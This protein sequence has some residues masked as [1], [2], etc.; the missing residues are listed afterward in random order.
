MPWAAAAAVASAVVGGVAANKAASKAA[1]ANQKAIDANAYQ[2]QIALDQFDDY[3]TTFRPLEHSLASDAQQ[4][5]SAQGYERA[6]GEAQAAVSSQLGLARARLMRTPGL[7]PSSAAAQAAHTNL[8][9]HGAAMAATEQNL[10]R[11]R[12]RDKAFARKLDA[13]GLGRGLVANA[14]TGFAN[15]AS[16][17][18]SLARANF[19]EGNQTAAGIGSLVNGVVGGLSKVNW[20]KVG[21]IF[22]TGGSGGSTT[23]A[24]TG[25]TNP[26]LE[27]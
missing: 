3:K 13:A 20:D 10:A 21:G 9:L 2:G 17:A 7:D 6:A 26:I 27:I 19:N 23:P 16:T 18:S 22:G 25:E 5:D 1:D 24:S 11:E 8:E 14:S 15:A 4:Y 12:V